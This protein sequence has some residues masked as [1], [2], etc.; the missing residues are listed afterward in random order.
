M[1]V[2]LL[3]T[4]GATIPIFL[5]ISFSMSVSAEMKLPIYLKSFT[6]SRIFFHGV[7]CC[8]TH[9]QFRNFRYIVIYIR[10][11]R[12]I[13]FPIANNYADY[14]TIYPQADQK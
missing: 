5:D 2:S 9:L 3:K 12:K 4:C 11:G 7:N 14:C 8:A 1:L 6:S 10:Y 13:I